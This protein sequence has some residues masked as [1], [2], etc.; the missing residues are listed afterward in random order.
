MSDSHDVDDEPLSIVGM[1]T[2]PEESLKVYNAWALQYEQDVRKWGYDMP[3]KV[4]RT[5][6][7]HVSS[8]AECKVLDAG[9]GSGLSGGALQEA[10][11]TH[12]EASDLS[13]K[14]LEIAKSRNCYEKVRVVDM[15]QKL[16]PYSDDFSM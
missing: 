11:F 9:A 16:L 2:D 15:N 6:R 8:S 13:P 3:Q 14:M 7:K 4:A 5:L 10:C 1:G 12:V